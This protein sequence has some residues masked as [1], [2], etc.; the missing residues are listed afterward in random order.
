MRWD[1]TGLFL[2]GHRIRRATNSDPTGTSPMTQMNE[3][4]MCGALITACHA[5]GVHCSSVTAIVVIEELSVAP[6][7]DTSTEVRMLELHYV[8]IFF[9]GW[10][11]INV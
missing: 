3:V 11:L 7:L 6:Y 8:F 9:K 4:E 1:L 10:Q 2:W 5:K